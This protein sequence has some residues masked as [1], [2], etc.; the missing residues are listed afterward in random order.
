MRAVF[1]N[2]FQLLGI[3]LCSGVARGLS[4]ALRVRRRNDAA[5]AVE[6]GAA[7]CGL[8]GGIEGVGVEV[9][10]V[11]AQEVCLAGGNAAVDVDFG[12]V[13]AEED[14]WERRV[15]MLWRC[16]EAR[17]GNGYTFL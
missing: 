16:R 4:V 14:L 13:A 15:S 12:V 1:C 7:G 3:L 10:G 8:K 9:W 2:L 5:E 6:V 11:G 17:D